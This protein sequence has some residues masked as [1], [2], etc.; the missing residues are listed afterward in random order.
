MYMC[1]YVAHVSVLHQDNVFILEYEPEDQ[2]TC[3]FFNDVIP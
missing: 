3:P 1:L 2:S